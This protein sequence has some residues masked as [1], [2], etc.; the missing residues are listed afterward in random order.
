MIKWYYYHIIYFII[1][2]KSSFFDPAQ[3]LR[4]EILYST[5]ADLPDKM[6][7]NLFVQLKILFYVLY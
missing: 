7:K 2:V 4:L 6:M 3:E 5:R 1:A